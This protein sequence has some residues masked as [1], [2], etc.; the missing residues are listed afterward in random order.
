[1]ARLTTWSNGQETVLPDTIP[2]I[3]AALPQERRGDFDRAVAGASVNELHAVLRHWLFELAE[4]DQERE[5]TEQLRER[6]RHAS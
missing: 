5:L 2:G 6:E 4:D 1:M 3:R